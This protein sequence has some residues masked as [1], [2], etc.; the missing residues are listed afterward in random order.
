MASTY[1]LVDYDSEEERLKN[2]EGPPAA[3]LFAA[4]EYISGLFNANSVDY[5]VMGGFAMICRGSFRTTSDV[6]VVA[7]ATMSAL[8]RI[9]EPQPRLIIPNTKLVSGVIRVF[10]KT[11]FASGDADC[12]QNWNVE[13]DLIRPGVHGTPLSVRNNM[14]N[15]LVDVFGTTLTFS[16][17][18]ILYMMRTK[19][20]CCSSRGFGRDMGDLEYLLKHEGHN[21]TAI[22]DQLDEGDKEFFLGTAFVRD[23]GDEVAAHWRALLRC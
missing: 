16:G 23:K 2:P 12:P 18:N 9:I 20:K 10:V 21:V 1:N 7:E 19:L 6:D 3:N 14:N 22:A 4:A 11:G 17:L 13:V 8:W 15:L 5:A